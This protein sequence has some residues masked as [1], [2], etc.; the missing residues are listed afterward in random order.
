[1]EN[2]DCLANGDCIFR[3]FFNLL[4]FVEDYTLSNFKFFDLISCSKKERE[5]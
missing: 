2:R 4:G 5:E 3:F 1:M